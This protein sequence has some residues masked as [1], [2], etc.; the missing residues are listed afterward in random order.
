MAASAR[1]L[2]VALSLSTM[3][4]HGWEVLLLPDQRATSTMAASSVRE[5]CLSRKSQTWRTRT[6]GRTRSAAWPER[7]FIASL[8]SAGGDVNR[9]MAPLR[10]DEATER[11]SGRHDTDRKS[12]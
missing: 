2:I 8:L 3:N 7:S 10:R 4:R 11:A 6:S 9:P 5:T 12:V 1:R